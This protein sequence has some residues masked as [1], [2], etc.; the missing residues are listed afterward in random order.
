MNNTE[1]EQ[2]VMNDEPLYRDYLQ[3]KLTHP[4]TTELSYARKHRAEIDEYVRQILSIEPT[5]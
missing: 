4:R 1:R 3:Y 5:S 2:W